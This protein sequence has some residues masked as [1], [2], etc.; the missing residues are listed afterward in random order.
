MGKGCVRDAR[1]VFAS[2][3]RRILNLVTVAAKDVI[4]TL[5]INNELL[6][7]SDPRW[8][9]LLLLSKGI[10]EN[11][12]LL[13]NTIRASKTE[14]SWQHLRIKLNSFQ[15][16]KHTTLNLLGILYKALNKPS[17]FK[18]YS[19]WA[20]KIEFCIACNSNPQPYQIVL[21][22]LVCRRKKHGIALER[23]DSNQKTTP[24]CE[25]V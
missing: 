7:Y 12:A 3:Y 9:F 24:L 11:P 16:L 13:Y 23:T 10:F 2:I 17:R 20:V 19:S 4:H 1:I 22:V 18:I 15:F 6:L 25:K 21:V 5:L 8:N 14:I